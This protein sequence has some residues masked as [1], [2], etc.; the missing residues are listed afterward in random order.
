MDAEPGRTSCATGAAA[1]VH[2]LIGLDP[3]GGRGPP[4]IF[5]RFGRCGAS[6]APALDAPLPLPPPPLPLLP[7]TPPPLLEPSPPLPE[8]TDD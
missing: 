3:T 5:V 7:E 6:G 8:T 2:P 4:P 1:S